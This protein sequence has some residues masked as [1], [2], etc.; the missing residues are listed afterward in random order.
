MHSVSPFLA[1]LRQCF[2]SLCIHN[3]FSEMDTITSTGKLLF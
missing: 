1:D 2:P 3:L